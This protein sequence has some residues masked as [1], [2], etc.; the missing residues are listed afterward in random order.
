VRGLE[1]LSETCFCHLKSIL[2]PNIGI[3][4]ELYEKIRETCMPR[5]EF[6][7]RYFPLP[8]LQIS[9][10]IVAFFEKIYHSESIL[11]VISNIG[12]EVQYRCINPVYDV[13]YVSLSDTMPILENNYRVQIIEIG[14]AE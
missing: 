2:F 1:L 4:S 5:S 8:T 9:H 3:A 7:H 6:K 13:K 12:E 11:T 10:G 14:F